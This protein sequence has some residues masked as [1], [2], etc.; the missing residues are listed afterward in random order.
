MTPPDT[1]NTMHIEPPDGDQD[2][3]L[4]SAGAM[5]HDRPMG[6]ESEDTDLPNKRSCTIDV[7]LDDRMASSS[8]ESCVEIETRPINNDSSSETPEQ[9]ENNHQKNDDC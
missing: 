8:E 7:E 2:A 9:A 1:A 6:S 4:G 5:K 3:L